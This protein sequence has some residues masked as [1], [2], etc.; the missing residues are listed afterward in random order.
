MYNNI[1]I[2]SVGHNP[3]ENN[4]NPPPPAEM[5]IFQCVN[6]RAR[7]VVEHLKAKMM[8]KRVQSQQQLS[9]PDQFGGRGG[10]MMDSLAPPYEEV[11]NEHIMGPRM[12]QAQLVGEET[13][14]EMKYCRHIW[15]DFN[16]VFYF[17]ITVKE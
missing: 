5:H 9:P 16:G 14:Y 3:S 7:D 17:T 12:V 13:R 10:K 2:Y 1:L 4:P 8:G 6:V 11:E 15:R